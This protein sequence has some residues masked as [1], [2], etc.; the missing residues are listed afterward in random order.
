MAQ[1][2][3]TS[4]ARAACEALTA[5]ERLSVGFHNHMVGLSKETKAWWKKHQPLDTKRK[6]A[7]RRK[8]ASAKKKVARSGGYQNPGK[9][10]YGRI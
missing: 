2:E 3:A 5:L 10:S 1:K 8:K 4:A 7:T 6:A 9:K